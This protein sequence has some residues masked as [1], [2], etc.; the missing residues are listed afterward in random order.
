MSLF[1]CPVYICIGFITIYP[2]C[3]YIVTYALGLYSGIWSVFTV[4]C[5]LWITSFN[6]IFM[7]MWVLQGYVRTVPIHVFLILNLQLIIF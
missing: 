1:Y 7:F 5:D 3:T 6:T 4:F 2:I